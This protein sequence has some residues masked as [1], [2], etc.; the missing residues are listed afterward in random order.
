MSEM[1]GDSL[2]WAE[3]MAD[4]E[5]YWC[6]ATLHLLYCYTTHAVMQHFTSVLQ[7]YTC[8]TATLHCYTAPLHWLYCNT[9]SVVLQHNTCFITKLHFLYCNTSLMYCNNTL[10]VL[11]NTTLAVLKYCISCSETLPGRR[12]VQGQNRN[13]CCTEHCIIYSSIFLSTVHHQS[14]KS[15]LHLQSGSWPVVDYSS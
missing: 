11:I 13:S 7:H 5:R 3:G 15:H 6:T 9:T 8:C 2:W 14:W 4:R 12:W 1:Q 10:G